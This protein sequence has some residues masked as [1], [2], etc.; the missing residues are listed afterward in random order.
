MDGGDSPDTGL[1]PGGPPVTFAVGAVSLTV[2]PTAS[3]TADGGTLAVSTDA[4]GSA[5]LAVTSSATTAT[6]VARV[7]APD[8]MSIEVLA[9]GSAV[10][11]DG[12]G[13]VA[14]ISPKRARMAD[15]GQV[16][17]S[18]DSGGA[19]WMADT[20]VLSLQWG[21]R[22][23]GRSLAV[24]PSAWGRSGSN[25]AT[26]MVWD[27]I[28]AEPGADG[29][30]MHDQLVCHQLGAPDKATWNLEP[31]RPEVDMITLGLAKCNPT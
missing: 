23:G 7:T 30:N 26:A 20:A 18:A 9:D 21:D 15:D 24:K 27:V 11:R 13:L 25:A 31:W 2:Q 4:D 28:A 3:F 14:G 22:E 6:T 5:R 17:L 10:V 19:L 12:H 1:E 29:Q 8:G 16:T